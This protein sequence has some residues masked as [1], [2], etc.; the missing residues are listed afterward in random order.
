MKIKVKIPSALQELTKGESEVFGEGTSIKSLLVDL[1]SQYPGLREKVYN[2]DGKLQQFISV[3]VN[4]TNI[5]SLQ[6]DLTP[7]N[8]GDEVAVISAVTSV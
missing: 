5:R 6:E 7:L 8:E 4:D 1:N 3:F 2:E